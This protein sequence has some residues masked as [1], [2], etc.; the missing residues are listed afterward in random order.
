M[1]FVDGFLSLCSAAGSG[2][3]TEMGLSRQP[4]SFALTEARHPLTLAAGIARSTR[5]VQFPAAG[6]TG[7][8][9]GFGLFDSPTG[10]DLLL[11]LPLYAPRPPSGGGWAYQADVGDLWLS[12]A[13]LASNPLP[14]SFSG[15]FAAGAT[16]GSFFDTPEIVGPQSIVSGGSY[17]AAGL[18]AMPATSGVALA[19]FRG[20]LAAASAAA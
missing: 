10:G 15:T 3:V 17:I 4:I 8:A 13:A 20:T 12:I 9:A 2:A 5:P 11:A 19:I 6:I 14:E 1:S 18:Q 7:P 16:L